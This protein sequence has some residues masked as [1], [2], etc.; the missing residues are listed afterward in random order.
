MN[1]KATYTVCALFLL[2]SLAAIAD[3][4]SSNFDISFGKRRDSFDS[5]VV[6]N[7]SSWSS[8]SALGLD[9]IKIKEFEVYQ[10]GLR[11]HWVL[12]M[13]WNDCC[14]FSSCDDWYLGQFYLR[15]HAYWGW[16]KDG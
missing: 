13:I 3:Q 11:G 15:Y 10:V 2:Y 8:S 6:D 16:A 1:L 12:P 5:K 14:C 4:P 7:A 9:V